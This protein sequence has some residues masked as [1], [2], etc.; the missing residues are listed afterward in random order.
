VHPAAQRIN[1]AQHLHQAH[2]GLADFQIDDEAHDSSSACVSRNRLR[3]APSAA[4]SACVE[5][6]VI[7]EAARHSRSVTLRVATVS[8]AA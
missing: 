6:I 5:S 7:M 8:L 1:H 2:R 3:A 4:P